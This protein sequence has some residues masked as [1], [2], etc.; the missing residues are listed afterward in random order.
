MAV[1][2]VVSDE[3][4][5]SAA[6]AVDMVDT[7]RASRRTGDSGLH[8]FGLAAGFVQSREPAIRKASVGGGTKLVSEL[9]DEFAGGAA[10]VDSIVDA[11][12]RAVNARRVDT[13][14]PSP[15]SKENYG[16]PA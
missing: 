7:P 6:A 11:G 12:G 3:V 15:L 2:V 10:A 8:K 5:V 9:A 4:D 13:S 14:Q 16:A 1:G